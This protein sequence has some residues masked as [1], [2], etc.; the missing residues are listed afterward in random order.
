MVFSFRVNGLSHLDSFP[1]NYQRFL[2]HLR[3]GGAGSYRSR[4]IGSMLADFHR[5]LLRGGIFMYPPTF[6]HPDGKLRLLYEA[7][8]IAMI[9][10]QAGGVATNG[11]SRILEIQPTEVHQRTALIVGSTQEMSLFRRY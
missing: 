10:E 6:G 5:T 7:N 3:S 8:P 11:K 4:C 2:T 9:A 1:K